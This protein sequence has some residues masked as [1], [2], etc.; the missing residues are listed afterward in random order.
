M[1][2]FLR[3]KKLGEWTISRQIPRHNR[4]GQKNK[5]GDW[6]QESNDSPKIP[7]RGKMSG[8]PGIPSGKKGIK[9]MT[10][11]LRYK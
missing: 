3:G 6:K 8:I 11:A 5:G 7:D 1:E 2:T 10:V 9:T 4:T